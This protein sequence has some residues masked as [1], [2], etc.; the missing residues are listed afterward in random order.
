[1]KIYL[2]KSEQKELREKGTLEIERE[3]EL[4]R[5]H[6]EN[7]VHGIGTDHLWDKIDRKWVYGNCYSYIQ[8]MM[9]VGRRETDYKGNTSNIWSSGNWWGC[10]RDLN[11]YGKLESV[12]TNG[13]K[14]VI[15]FRL[16]DIFIFLKPDIEFENYNRVTF[17]ITIKLVK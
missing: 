14:N 16:F 4:A 3:P 2:S 11:E 9:N 8:E 6:K 13:R 10:Q 15:Q 1:M 5:T 7:F 17:K 12:T